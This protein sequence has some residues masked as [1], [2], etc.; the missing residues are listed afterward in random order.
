MVDDAIVIVEN[1]S[2]HIEKGLP[3]KE[4]T[5]KAM[6]EMTGPVMGITL[7]LTA[8]FLPAAFL[9][10]ITGQLFRQ[11]ALVIA[12]TAVISAINALTLKPAQCALWLRPASGEEAQP[13]FPGLQPGLWGHGG[14]LYRP[15]HPDG[16]AP[17]AHAAGVYRHYCGQR[18]GGSS[19]HPTGFLPTEDQGYA[20]IV[21]RLPDGASQ[22]RVQAVAQEIN[23]ILKK[24]KGLKAWVTIGGFSILDAAKSPTSSPPLSFIRT[25]TSAAPP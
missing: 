25:G 2:Y 10:G 21:A 15:G 11:F 7:V 17:R 3:P 6:E 23:A 18:P 19:D 1:T 4:A 12:S 16:A 9:P 14:C 13:V 5:I 8:V 24:T 20:I 22:P